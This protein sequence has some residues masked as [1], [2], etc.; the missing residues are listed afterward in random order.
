MAGFDVVLTPDISLGKSWM[1]AMLAI[2]SASWLCPQSSGE[3]FYRSFW[4]NYE[5]MEGLVTYLHFCSLISFAL[6]GNAQNGKVWSWLFNTSL[7]ASVIMAF[8]GIFQLWGIFQT[9]QG[10]RLDVTLGNA[11]Y[12][13][14]YMVFHI[15]LAFALFF[16]GRKI[17]ENGFI[18]LLSPWNHSLLLYGDQRG[19]IRY[20]RRLVDCLDFN[21][22][23]F[24]EQKI[25]A[26]SRLRC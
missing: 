22:H 19:D 24:S 6:A 13:A 17:S 26:C 11:S 25:K 1:L 21:R 23:Y 14:I 5:R 8:Y 16:T 20:N 2:L 10:N 15:F 3:N 12:L 18:L 9:H 4:S 7:F